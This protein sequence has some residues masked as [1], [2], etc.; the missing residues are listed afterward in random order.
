MFAAYFTGFQFSDM[1]F[2]SFI[3]FEAGDLQGY[4]FSLAVTYL[5][6]FSLIVILYFMCR[7]YDRYKQTHR[8]WWL[9]Y[10]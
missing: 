1:V 5:V 6:W 4:G 9:S 3:F 8:H 10:L 7:W 2:D